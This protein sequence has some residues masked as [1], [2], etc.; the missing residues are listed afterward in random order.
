[1][2]PDAL[3]S[4]RQCGHVEPQVQPDREGL[5]RILLCDVASEIYEAICKHGGF[6]SFLD[7]FMAWVQGRPPKSHWCEHC[8]P[9]YYEGELMC[10]ELVFDNGKSRLR[11]HPKCPACPLCTAPRQTRTP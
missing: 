1:M 11:L 6:E 2:T 10:W 3:T 9:K 4:C 5:K 7:R 8:Q